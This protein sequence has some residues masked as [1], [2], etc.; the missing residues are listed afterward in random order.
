MFEKEAE[1]YARNK[2]G[3]KEFELITDDDVSKYE[4]TQKDWQKG[5]E[6]GYNKCKEEINKNGLAL[7]L[8]MDRTIEQNM[9]LKK[10]I[11]QMK[12]CANCVFSESDRLNGTFCHKEGCYV[13][14][15][16]K[17]KLWESE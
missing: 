6:F 8:D 1:E 15:S 3:G 9:A 12:C 4:E 7:Q 13:L 10:L 5:A 2:M 17:C 14:A 16:S 11:E